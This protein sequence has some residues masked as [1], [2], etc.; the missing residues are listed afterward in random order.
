MN[1]LKRRK[2]IQN[3]KDKWNNIKKWGK[4]KIIM[5]KKLNKLSKIIKSCW[6]L[7]RDQKK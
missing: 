2:K 7:L 3:F 1:Y 4:R 6:K 5:I